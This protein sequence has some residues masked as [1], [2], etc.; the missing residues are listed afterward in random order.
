MSTPLATGR[1]PAAA[2]K[3]RVARFMGVEVYRAEIYESKP[4]ENPLERL[5]HPAP[6][7]PCASGGTWTG[8]SGGFA[9][10]SSRNN[11]YLVNNIKYL[12]L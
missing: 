5:S 1:H 4:P 6:G 9:R 3:G 7:A 10:K 2:G 11:P 8:R 12:N